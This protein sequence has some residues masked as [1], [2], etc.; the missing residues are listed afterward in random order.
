MHF[1]PLLL[2][3]VDPSL[4]ILH[5]PLHLLNLLL[6]GQHSLLEGLLQQIRHRLALDSIVAP[7]TRGVAV[8][9]GSGHG[10]VAHSVRVTT[11]TGRTSA[12]TR[13]MRILISVLWR[14]PRA[15]HISRLATGRTR[16][17]L[18]SVVLALLVGAAA[19]VRSR[20]LVPR[21]SV[22]IFEAIALGGVVAV[23]SVRV[24]VGARTPG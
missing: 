8:H 14:G 15:V 12:R 10:R 2:Q 3:L 9:G 11:T 20:A 23:V 22:V 1:L 19:A 21:I 18:L 4:Y 13:V 24:R 17:I 6:V 16:R 5:L 7:S